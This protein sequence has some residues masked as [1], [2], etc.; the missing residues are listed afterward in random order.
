MIT[1]RN[2]LVVSWLLGGSLALLAGCGSSVDP[3]LPALVPVSGQVTLDGAP[4]SD[5]YV[6]FMP[7][8]DTPGRGSG[9]TTGEDGRYELES[10][11]GEG[12]PVGQYRVTVSKLVNPDGSVFV[13]T[14]EISPMDSGAR[15]IVPRRWSD[16]EITP[17]TA[18]VPEGGGSLDFELESSP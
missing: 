15:E 9:A 14:D 3:D 4:L 5:A 18:E 1:P 8:G 6:A 16:P 12:A 13:P 7:E 11:H 17:L 10:Q 2:S